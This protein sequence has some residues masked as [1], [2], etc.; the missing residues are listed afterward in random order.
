LPSDRIL[1][2]AIDRD[3]RVWVGT[4]AGLAIITADGIERYATADGLASNSI[5][6][7]VL[8]DNG[9]GWLATPSGISVLR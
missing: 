1:S 4:D 8:N 5:R 9:E 2:L 6:D 3:G 7:I